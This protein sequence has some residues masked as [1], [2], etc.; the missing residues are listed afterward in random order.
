MYQHRIEPVDLVR[1]P[2]AVLE[3]IDHFIEIPELAVWGDGQG[4]YFDRI[5]K[6]ITEYYSSAY[7]IANLH[8]LDPDLR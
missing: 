6:E 5:E 1:D 7:G 8:Q 4:H 2:A 3:K